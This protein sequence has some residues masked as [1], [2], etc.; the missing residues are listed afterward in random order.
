[1]LQHAI[2]TIP[3]R[4]EGYTTDDNARGL[5]LTVLLAQLG[6]GN[7]DDNGNSNSNNKDRFGPD[8]SRRYL[9]FLEHAFNPANCRFR[10]FLSYDR[11]WNEPAGSEDCHGRALWSLGTVLG[12]SDNQV[13]RSAAGRLFEFSLPAALE[14]YSPRAGAY[15]LLGIQG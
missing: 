5:I 8:F 1:M 11:R 2:F 7:D 14:S 15:A 9:S 10:N 12:R 6:N 3:N 13:L 4:A